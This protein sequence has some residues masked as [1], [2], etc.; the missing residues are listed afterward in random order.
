MRREPCRLESILL[1]ASADSRGLCM[2]EMMVSMTAGFIMLGAVLQ[3]FEYYDTRF[4]SQQNTIAENQDFRLGLEV[5]EQELRLA[6]TGLSATGPAIVRATENE[7]E[8]FANLNGYRTIVTLPAAAGDTLLSVADGSGW[9]KGKTVMVCWVERCETF[10]LSQDGHHH[11]L[12]SDRSL[13]QPIPVGASV[14]IVNRV[15]YYNKRDERG[16]CRILRMVDGG[17]SVLI[18]DGAYARF[19]YWDADGHPAGGTGRIKRI[20]MKLFDRHGRRVLSREIGVRL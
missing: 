7:I 17:A 13:T 14:T 1:N 9:G 16:I 3:T 2:A 18:G 10:S 11:S 20:V 4:V 8:F 15:R 5:V 19:S 6:G 12:V